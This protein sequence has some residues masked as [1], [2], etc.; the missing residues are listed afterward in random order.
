MT[1]QQLGRTAKRWQVHPQLKHLIKIKHKRLS[2]F[3][4]NALS[5]D[6][7]IYYGILPSGIEEDWKSSTLFL[8][9]QPCSAQPQCSQYPPSTMSKHFGRMILSVELGDNYGHQM[10][11]KP[12]GKN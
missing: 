9:F 1:P 2:K 11:K 8:P 12:P 5:Y 4:A 10:G 6:S 7:E 3:P